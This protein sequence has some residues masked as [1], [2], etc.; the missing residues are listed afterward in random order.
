M[1]N[2]EPQLHVDTYGEDKS[3]IDP[4]QRQLALIIGGSTIDLAQQTELTQTPE[5]EGGES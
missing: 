3:N 2:L 1:S 5:T 4:L